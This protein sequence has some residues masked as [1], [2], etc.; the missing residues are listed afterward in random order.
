MER[1]WR[2]GKPCEK[3]QVFDRKSLDWF[4]ENGFM[5]KP[6]PQLQW[7]LYPRMK[8]QKLRFEMP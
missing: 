2:L 8:E 6:F 3:R 4:A 5:L 1:G 7:Y